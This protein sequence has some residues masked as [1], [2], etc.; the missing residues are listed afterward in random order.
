M[1]HIL[2]VNVRINASGVLLQTMLPSHH[3][4]LRKTLRYAD[5]ELSSCG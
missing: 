5:E 3:A 4:L 1:D 2:V